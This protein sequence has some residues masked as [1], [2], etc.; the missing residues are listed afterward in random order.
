LWRYPSFDLKWLNTFSL[1][2]LLNARKYVK[3][4]ITITDDKTIKINL[5][6][7]SSN[8]KCIN[9]GNIEETNNIVKHIGKTCLKNRTIEND[10]IN[11]FNTN[12]VAKNTTTYI[13]IVASMGI[14]TFLVDSNK[15]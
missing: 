15:K 11:D 13:Q 5:T 6:Q 8:E 9:T 10:F 12:S 4:V 2:S 14:Y 3:T 7:P 1:T